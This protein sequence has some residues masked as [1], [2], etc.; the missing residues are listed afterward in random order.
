M[1]QPILSDENFNK[2]PQLDRIEYRQRE[3]RLGRKFNSSFT[4]IV[5]L[6]AYAWFIIGI[7]LTGLIVMMLSLM[8]TILK[9]FVVVLLIT[10]LFDL[11][12]IN[13]KKKVI[14]ELQKEYLAKII[15]VHKQPI[16]LQK[17]Y[18]SDKPI[19]ELKKKAG[20]PKKQN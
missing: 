2:L 6:T 18:L 5:M 16:M 14:G 4:A 11:W 15:G 19:S 10:M 3:D 1:R 17:G 8:V 13:K 7:L 9:I 20:R 12:M